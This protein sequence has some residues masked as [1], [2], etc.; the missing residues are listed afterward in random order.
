MS[1]EI[2]AIAILW[3]LGLGLMLQ[4]FRLS[5]SKMNWTKQLFCCIFWFLIT[6]VLLIVFILTEKH[7]EQP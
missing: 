5:Q 6:F 3:L 1:I 4:V 2:A 7:D